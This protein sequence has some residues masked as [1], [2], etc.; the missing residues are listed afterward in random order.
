MAGHWE[1]DSGATCPDGLREVDI[2]LRVAQLV[3][4][5]LREQGY[6]AEVLPEYSDRLAGYRALACVSLHADSCLPELSGFKVAGRSWGAA[7]GDSVRL[8]ESLTRGY[9]T[10]TALGYHQDTITPAMTRYHNFYRVAPH[11][12]IAIVE[13]GFMGGD[14]ELL[15]FHQDRVARGIVAGLLDFL[16]AEPALPDIPAATR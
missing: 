15:T 9:A 16:E 8:V 2:T 5:Q 14:R 11:T 10:V 6:Q 3:A 4:D 13:L 12:P 1:Y 7:A